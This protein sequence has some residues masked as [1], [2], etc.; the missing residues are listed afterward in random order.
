MVLSKTMSVEYHF[1]NLSQGIPLVVQ[2]LGLGAL[3]ARAGVQSLAGEQRSHKPRGAAKKKKKEFIREILTNGS[4]Y[5]PVLNT[6]L[7]YMLFWFLE[8]MSHIT[9]LPD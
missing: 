7:L 1:K 6:F 9:E 4:Q 8:N 5:D 3:V 2:L